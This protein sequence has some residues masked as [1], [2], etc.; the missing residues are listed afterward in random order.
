M[1]VVFALPGP[2]SREVHLLV[3]LA[4]LPVDADDSIQEQS[5]AEEVSLS[6]VFEESP[7]D[8][9]GHRRTPWA[10]FRLVLDRSTILRSRM[11][12]LRQPQRHVDEL[13]LEPL[14]VLRHSLGRVRAMPLAGCRY[15][16]VSSHLVLRLP[17]LDAAM[18]LPIRRGRLLL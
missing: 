14:Q 3:A 16:E 8:P 2:A 1:P 15:V 18:T 6:F 12:A 11:S 10:L 7:M 9:I 4:D 17:L 5:S 13:Q